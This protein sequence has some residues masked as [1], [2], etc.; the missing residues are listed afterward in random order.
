M[1][2]I[3]KS[4]EPVFEFHVAKKIREK[5]D[6]DESF[7][8]L[9]G[10]VIFANFYQVRLFVQKLNDK[11]NISEHVSPGEING[12]GLLDEIY[13]LSIKNYVRRNYPNAFSS[14]I[15]DLELKLGEEKFDKLLLDFIKKFPPKKVYKNEETETEYLNG[16][17]EGVTNREILIEELILLHISNKNPALKKLKELF[18]ENHFDEKLVYKNAITNLRD[19]FK[20]EELKIGITNSDLFDFL[21]LPFLKY[22][23]S[24][25]D[26]L[27][28]IKNEWGI[29]ID[30]ALLMKIQSSKDLFV[31]SIKFE[32]NFGGGG[33]APTIVPKYKGQLLDADHLVIGK[34]RFKYAEESSYEYE[35]NEQFTPDVNWM[36]NLVLIAKNIYVWLDQLSKKYQREI[37]TLDQIPIEELQLLRSRNING[38]WLIGVWERSSASKRIKHLMGNID[39]VASAYSLFDY[40]IAHDLGGENAY[41]IFNQRAKESGIRLASDMVPNHTGIY[42]RWMKEHPDYFIQLDYPPFPNYR[43]TG[44]NLSEHPDFEIRIEDQY[45]QMKDAAVVFE[46]KD[47]ING[48]TKYFYHGNDGTNMPWNDTAQLDLLKHEVREALIQKIFDVARKFSVIRFDAAMTLAKKH[49]ARLWY[50]QPGKGGDIP[51]RA[52]FAMSRKQFDEFFPKEF[53]REVV[54]RINREMPE[55]LLLAEAFWLMEGYFVRTLGM[56][57]VYN[58]AFMNMM[59]NE[60]NA[61]YRELITNTLEFEPEILKRYVNFMSNP[62]E[63]TAIDQF[64]SGD[65]Y[66][67]VLVLMCTLPGLP[68]FAHGQIEGFTEKYGMEYKRAYYDEQPQQWLVERHEKEIFPIL[69]KRFVFSEINNFWIYD[70]VDQ[71]G[72]LNEN[73]F[74]Y[75]NEAFGEKGLVIF[76]NSFQSYSGFFSHSRQKLTGNS[77]SSNS[78]NNTQ[79]AHRL[80]I[81]KSDFHFYIMRDITTGLEYLYNGND[82]HSKGLFLNLSGYEYRVYLYFEEIFDPSG[83]TYKFYKKNFGLGVNNIKK[84]L[85]KIKLSS[86]HKAFEKVFSKEIIGLQLA[87]IEEKKLTVKKM[88][89]LEQ[90]SRKNLTKLVVEISKNFRVVEDFEEENKK[91]VES[92]DDFVRTINNLNVELNKVKNKS[93]TKSAIQKKKDKELLKLLSFKANDN[94]IINSIYRTVQG[95]KNLFKD[96]EDLSKNYISELMLTNPIKKILK[97]HLKNI[98]TLPTKILLINILL[99]LEEKIE[100]WDSIPE[101]FLT[102]RSNKKLLEILVSNNKTFLKDFFDRELVNTFLGM[103]HY[104]G[105]NYFSKESLEDFVDQLSVHIIIVYNKILMKKIKTKTKQIS[106]LER[107]SKKVFALSNYIKKSAKESGYLYDEF[108]DVIFFTSHKKVIKKRKK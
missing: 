22:S 37:K 85:G 25:W 63:E 75:S 48:Q 38:L 102:Q 72:K 92:T 108:L 107:F 8:S 28:Y 98:E 44:E 43:F 9:N 39:A 56:H 97:D 76:N 104:E 40:E 83:E 20:K 32:P 81:Q 66:F 29:L 59:M 93:G 64:D 100:E 18:D 80:G 103:N 95:L 71:S 3:N 87:L 106:E 90:K 15:S 73:V 42:S 24:I 30:E 57:R 77:S 84:E 70:F 46:R 1:E 5:Y 52:D 86:M 12:A 62:D 35:E 91:I 6:L 67:G 65:K 61:K 34:S 26:Q 10:N 33:G 55:T 96:D 27:E 45:F 36:P 21:S 58:S 54:D 4:F 14:A 49:F 60:E 68:M 23:S 11:R 89:P 16:K 105:K 7:F 82:L 53:W 50:P 99:Q 41:H 101:D 2:I 74:I 94:L 79:I 19:F 51:S 47:L 31:E 17:T 69:K 78:L 88:N 13:H